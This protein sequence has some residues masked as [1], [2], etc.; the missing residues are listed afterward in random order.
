MQPSKYH[1]YHHVAYFPFLSGRCFAFF[2]SVSDFL[3][4]ESFGMQLSNEI[5]TAPPAVDF[6]AC[7]LTSSP[8]DRPL[9]RFWS[10]LDRDLLDCCSQYFFLFAI[11]HQFPKAWDLFGELYEFFQFFF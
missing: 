5:V 3:N 2:E 7:R 4:F 11:F 1:V 10:Y 6:V 8:V 9:C